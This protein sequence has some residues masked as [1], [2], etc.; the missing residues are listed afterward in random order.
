MIILK[1]EVNMSKNTNVI[2]F[3]YLKKIVHPSYGSFRT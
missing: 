3:V 2:I 1:V